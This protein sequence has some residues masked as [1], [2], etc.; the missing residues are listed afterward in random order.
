[1]IAH[2]A[3]A[4]EVK[5]RVVLR[6]GSS[7]AHPLAI[8]AAVRVAHAFQAE[9]E[10]L[11]VEDQ[12]LFDVTSHSFAREIGFGGRVRRRLSAPQLA[13]DLEYAAGAARRVVD[14]IARP[15]DVRIVHHTVRADPL[16]ALQAACA[17]VGPWNVIA[18]SEPL[19]AGSE[20]IVRTLMQAVTEAQGLIAVGAN[21]RRSRGPVLVAL[22]AIDHLSSMMR[23]ADRIARATEDEIVVVMIAETA[24]AI[25]AMDAQAR[26]MLA[27]REGV[28]LVAAL[29][30][31]GEPGPVLAVLHGL[32]GSFLLAEFGGLAVPADAGFAMA[33]AVLACPVFLVR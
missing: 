22:E 33:V 29:S 20:P 31:H 7:V 11:F 5:G 9:I 25:A 19:V 16:A 23:A 24:D 30:P 26:L 21:A 32:G 15:A 3:E 17:E 2:V 4:G 10:A 18:L 27:P 14:R 28:R 12:D 8:A 6:L 13:A 1:M